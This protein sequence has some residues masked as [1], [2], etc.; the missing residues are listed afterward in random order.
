[1]KI[2]YL[3]F[4]NVNGNLRV[5]DKREWNSLMEENRRLP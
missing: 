1:M 5:A 4:D 2:T 3:V